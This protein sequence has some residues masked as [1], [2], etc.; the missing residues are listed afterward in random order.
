MHLRIRHLTTYRYDPPRER[1]ALRLKLYPSLF[2][3]QKTIAW[4]VCVNGA[5]VP[6][7]LTTGV[8]D[9]QSIWTAPG[10][11]SEVA[12]LA[13][14]EVETKDAAGMV[15]GLKDSSRPAVFLRSTPLTQPSGPISDLAGGLGDLSGVDRLHAL[16][17]AVR[18][19]IDYVSGSTDVHT[20]AAEAIKRGKGVCQDHAH[21][22]I[23]AARALNIP[24]RYVVGYLL[25]DSE[26]SQ[27]GLAQTHTWAE[28]FVP[29]VGW[30]GFDPANELC[31]TDRYV[32]LGC[33]LDSSDA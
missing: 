25:P 16:L 15:R 27:A 13:E 10:A 29:E 4:K 11:L 30:I 24:A 3:G 22:F 21:V 19:A 20:T 14:G 18:S 9:R 1:C 26:K 5:T 8:G 33:G 17:H 6:A 23:A 7:L 31:P 12:I 28:A 32:R 2:D